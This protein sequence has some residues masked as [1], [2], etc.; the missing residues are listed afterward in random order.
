MSQSTTP[1][2]SETSS[3]WVA[4][5]ILPLVVLLSGILIAFLCWRRLRSNNPS[6][7]APKYLS[8]SPAS[9]QDSSG[10]PPS[11]KSN[12]VLLQYPRPLFLPHSTSAL[13]RPVHRP[14]PRSTSS[15]PS[16]S[17]TLNSQGSR[18]IVKKSRRSRPPEISWPVQLETYSPKNLEPR[19]LHRVQVEGG[20]REE[21]NGETDLHRGISQVTGYHSN[22]YAHP[23][24]YPYHHSLI[25]EASN[26]RHSWSSGDDASIHFS[27]LPFNSLLAPPPLRRARSLSSRSISEYSHHTVGATTLGRLLD[28]EID[29]VARQQAQ[30]DRSSTPLVPFI[31]TAS[32]RPLDLKSHQRPQSSADLYS[33]HPISPS[34]IPFPRLPP[35]SF[36]QP[37]ELPSTPSP[38]L[39]G[40]NAHPL[41][42]TRQLPVPS[43]PLIHPPVP[44]QQNEAQVKRE[45][46]ESGRWNEKELVEWRNGKMKER[47]KEREEAMKNYEE[48]E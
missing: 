23:Q 41:N 6:L 14:Q 48:E 19:P 28:E 17:T 7:K 10:S 1:R 5:L 31:A 27:T 8:H 29:R 15:F 12:S 37:Q 9:S 34:F 46:K 20:N 2:Y 42:S 39:H 4:A 36:S 26:T 18:I 32:T 35:V 11:T 40:D 43:I 21:R 13:I 47:R 24:S 45:R 22:S 16:V 44:S 33:I 38:M 25:E 3:L 30:F